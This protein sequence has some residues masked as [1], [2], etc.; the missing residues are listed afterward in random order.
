MLTNSQ[1]NTLQYVDLRT[2]KVLK[3]FESDHYTN[4]SQTNKACLSAGAQ[5]VLV[6]GKENIIVFNTK[7]AEVEDVYQDAHTSRV[8]GCYWQPIGQQFA[9]VD[10]LGGLIIWE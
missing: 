10:G 7:T 4:T 1:D 3:R 8:L 2:Y 5:Y 6:G 9:S